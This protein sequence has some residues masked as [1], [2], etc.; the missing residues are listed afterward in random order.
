MSLPV[1][2]YLA[3][4][5][6]S[7]PG[8]SV[9]P[10]APSPLDVTLDFEHK[11]DQRLLL[12]GSGSL[13]LSLGTLGPSGAQY[14]LLLIYQE[15][16]STGDPVTVT[17]N[18]ASAGARSIPPGGFILECL[19]VAQDTPAITIA[20]TQDASIVVVARGLPKKESAAMDFDPI[21]LLTALVSG[22][23]G[24]LLSTVF[25]RAG[26]IKTLKMS[27]GTLRAE[28]AAVDKELQ[29]LS[30]L[31]ARLD[32]LN[33]RV[34]ALELT[35]KIDDQVGGRIQSI[36]DTYG[37]RGEAYV[38]QRLDSL[39]RDVAQ[40]RSLVDSTI[41][42]STTGWSSARDALTRIEQLLSA[43]KRR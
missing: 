15:F 14:K 2:V 9:A 40:L 28:L 25:K 41:V 21:S 43:D 13:T 8:V 12:S 4:S 39:E 7:Q 38:V 35:D 34:A 23:G 22:S 11:I 17:F 31:A 42:E 30:A 3:L 33:K 24:G 5:E 37:R 32:E 27:I 20:Y 29:Q 10:L 19:P 6:P 18:G 26:D 1:S 36:A 16:S